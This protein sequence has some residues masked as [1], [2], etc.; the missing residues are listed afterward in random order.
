MSRTKSEFSGTFY[1]GK[2]ANKYPVTLSLTKAQLVLIFPDG[3]RISWL[4][5]NL[6]VSNTSSAGPV[7]LERTIAGPT[8][9]SEAVMIEDPDFLHQAHRIAPGA[10]G[11][12]WNQPHK[13]SLRY[14]LMILACII[15]PPFVFAVWVYVIPAMTDAVADQVPTTWEEKLGQDYFQA[16]F[17][18][19]IKE[20]DP[21]VRKAL[22]VMAKRFAFGGSG[23]TLQF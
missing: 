21:Q 10:L 9:I 11:T 14:A 17:K 19:S 4:Y 20:P 13:R 23:S 8:T 12:V 15:L 18:E 7:R 5:P 2:S 22:D 3:R 16:L 1:D 6:R